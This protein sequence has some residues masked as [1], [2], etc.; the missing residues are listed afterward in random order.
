LK[1]RLRR[2]WDELG[3]VAPLAAIGLLLFNDHYG[4][5]AFHNALTGKLSDVAICFL[6]PLLL[7]AGFGLVG[8]ANV[9]ARVLV[10][11]VLSAV[12]FTALELSD[13]AGVVFV[14]IMAKLGRRAIL[15]RDVTDLVALTFVPLSAAYALWRARS[16]S[17]AGT[18]R[19]RRLSGVAAAALGS[20][21]LM[22]DEPGPLCDHWTPP[23]VVQV[24]SGCGKGGLVVIEPGRWSGDLTF[25]NAAA[26]GL[27][28][29]AAHQGGTYHGAA[30]PFLLEEGDWD[31]TVGTC[32][33]STNISPS[34]MDASNDV[35]DAGLDAAM[36]PGA[37]AAIASMDGGGS[38]DAS[39]PDAGTPMVTCTADARVCTAAR[40]GTELWFTCRARDTSA[41]LCRSRLTVIP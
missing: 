11:A 33:T 13:G 32:S 12:L 16:F 19:A 6:L 27:P 31:V 1:R 14:H 3:G 28:E 18:S 2:A 22:A 34:P 20:L 39:A 7:A 4:K 8:W 40:E 26:L 35:D 38:P 24:E 36:D 5:R 30:C 37:D 25:Y 21:A 10:A 15:T 23:L 17:A 41:I 29:V 9:R